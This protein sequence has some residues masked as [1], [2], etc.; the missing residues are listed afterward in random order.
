MAEGSYFRD[1]TLC[2]L[3][4]SY[5]RFEERGALE[6][7]ATDHHCS[8]MI[9]GIQERTADTPVLRKKTY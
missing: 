9:H 1:V 4:S 2:R 5:R 3:L 6:T 8:D 7:P